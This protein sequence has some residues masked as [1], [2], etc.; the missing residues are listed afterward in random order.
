MNYLEK[1][2]QKWNVRRDPDIY[3]G[4]FAAMIE[5]LWNNFPPL[6][7]SMRPTNR[8]LVSSGER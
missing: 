2:R 4:C 1:I 5:G 6:R 3:L 7:P 8:V